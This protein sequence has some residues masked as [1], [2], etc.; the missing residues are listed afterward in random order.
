HLPHFVPAIEK[1]LPLHIPL[2]G[3][4]FPLENFGVKS[5]AIAIIA[6]ITIANYLSV[7][8]GNAIQL[9]S[10][11]MK[12]AALLLLVAGILFF[13]HGHWSNLV[14]NA[15]SFHPS[16]WLLVG[17]FAAATTGAFAAY[18]GWNSLPMMA[19]EIRDPARNIPKSLMIGV[20][21]CICIY[22]LVTL[23]Y[24]YVLPVDVMARSP[25]VASD[26]IRPVMGSTGNLVISVLII[27]CTFGA[28]SANLLANARV[29]FAMAETKS[30]FAWTG[31]IHRRFR[32]PGNAVLVLGVWSSLFVLSG[33]FDILADMFVFMS[34]VFYALVVIGLFRLRKHRPT[35]SRP[36]RVT[37]YPWLP[38]IFV[39]FT[40]FYLVLTVRYD[41]DNYRHGKSPF[42]NSIFGMLLTA[43]GIPLFFYFKIRS[44]SLQ[45]NSKR[46]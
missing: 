36:Y 42:I 45:Q 1:S 32:T 19:G 28:A 37:G 44:R 11:I 14:T 27:V 40:A 10:T 13:G 18:D 29:I 6:V 7:K 22:V 31:V 4:I 23:A 20:A 16:T 38:A 9:V 15:P 35:A 17:S 39:A 26:A 12:A 46:D 30:F 2:I 3:T 21:S 8:A 41:I 33:S 43:I 24:L 5:L 25:L 34:W